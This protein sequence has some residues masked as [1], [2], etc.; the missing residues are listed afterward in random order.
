MAIN[1]DGSDNDANKDIESGNEEG[2]AIESDNDDDVGDSVC[3][4]DEDEGDK[5]VDGDD[6]EEGDNEEEEIN[7]EE[8][9]KTP[10]EEEKAECNEGQENN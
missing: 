9:D 10:V 3:P 5:E 1:S 7:E 6:E 8:G 4:V 2:I